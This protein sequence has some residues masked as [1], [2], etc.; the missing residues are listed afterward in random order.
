MRG[1]PVTDLVYEAMFPNPRHNDPQNF[2]AL[3]HRYL[4]LEVRQEVQ[5]FYGHLDTQEAKYPGLDYCHSIHRIRLSRWQWHRRLFRAFD[6]LRLTHWEIAD[7]TKWEGTKWA[8]ERFER[9]SGIAI[10]DTASDGIVPYVEPEDRPVEVEHVRIAQEI[11]AEHEQEEEEEEL[12]LEVEVEEE[13]EED[14]G[15][16]I[17]RD[18]VEHEELILEEEEEIIE[19][20][21]TGDEA[22]D[23]SEEEETDNVLS[24]S[25]G[26]SLN[27][28]LLAQAAEHD[29]TGE[30]AQRYHQEL[31][32]LLKSAYDSGASMDLD[33]LQLPPN[34]LDAARA[35]QWD[36]ILQWLR[37]FI[38]PAAE[39][40]YG[41][42]RYGPPR[43]PSMPMPTVPT[44]RREL[45]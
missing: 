34:M 39:L 20:N 40:E 2:H 16:L 25:I 18:E 14:D 15:E 38:R 24:S 29:D 28:L 32:Q 19:E 1:R 12:E 6:A 36:G 3:L 4:I 5:S 21:D 10:Q 11:V 13:E 44:I 17:E 8:K 23:A 30:A 7:L 33:Q 41:P 9:D 26:Y 42:T 27:R 37:E 35:G 45:N 43:T 31:E 22:M